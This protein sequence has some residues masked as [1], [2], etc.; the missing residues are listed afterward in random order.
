[1]GKK[2]LDLYGG[3]T[4]GG[5][6]PRF[7]LTSS[8]VKSEGFLPDRQ[9]RVFLP[10]LSATTPHSPRPVPSETRLGYRS[11]FP[12]SPQLGNFPFQYFSDHCPCTLTS[13]SRCFD[14]GIGD[15]PTLTPYPVPDFT[16]TILVV[17]LWVPDP[18]HPRS[19][20]GVPHTSRSSK[21]ISQSLRPPFRPP[22]FGQGVV[23]GRTNDGV[24]P[25]V[26]WYPSMSLHT[27][28]PEDKSCP[29]FRTSHPGRYDG[30][31]FECFSTV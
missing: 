25:L 13:T 30:V 22:K 2:S 4:P 9:K 5:V 15:G 29:S 16:R 31:T 6:T 19:S 18:D 7:S 14:C 10:S 17:G 8:Q 20:I 21:K 1:M 11:P 24:P 27:R 3:R 28:V 12:D 26:V 23:E